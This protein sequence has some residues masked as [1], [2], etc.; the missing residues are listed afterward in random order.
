M[1]TERD[2]E[3][4][5]EVGPET[6]IDIIAAEQA[7]QIMVEGFDIDHD[8]HHVHGE[9]AA[10]ASC[11]A[12]PEHRRQ[13]MNRRRVDPTTRRTPLNWPFGDGWWKPTPHDRIRELA[14]AGALIA[15]EIDRLIRESRP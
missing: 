11:Y 4:P 5:D 13:P 10:A 2:T 6:G 12:L 9:L 8:D 3:R 15:S 1:S 14:K 7:R